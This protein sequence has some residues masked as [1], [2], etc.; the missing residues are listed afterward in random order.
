MDRSSERRRHTEAWLGSDPHVYDVTRI[1]AI[2]AREFERKDVLEELSTYANLYQKRE[3]SHEAHAVT[4]VRTWRF[5]MWSNISTLGCGL[6]HAKAIA[7]AYAMGLQEV[8]II[9]DDVQMI[10]VTD[11]AD[12]SELI[13]H[14]LRRLKESL[15]A[16]WQLLQL[17]STIYSPAKAAE[18]HNELM[19]RVIWHR[20]NGCAGD[21]YLILGAGAY[22]MSR[23]G[24][25]SY[26]Q[27]HLPESLSATIEEANSFH[28]LM[29]FRSTAISLIA[30]IAVYDL[31][32]VYTS[33]LP[34]FVPA[35]TVAQHS[36]IQAS[37]KGSTMPYAQHQLLQ[38]SVPALRDAGM[39]AIDSSNELLT[40]ALQNT[41]S[42]HVN[43]QAQLVQCMYNTR[44]VLVCE[45]GLHGREAHV[46]GTAMDPPIYDVSRA[47]LRL[48]MY[49][50]AESENRW[51]A[52]FWRTF[53]DSYLQRC[54]NMRACRSNDD[55]GVEMVHVL[56]PLFQQL[57]AIALP[58]HADN[59]A[60]AAAANRAC[61]HVHEEA[62]KDCSTAVQHVLESAI[63][64]YS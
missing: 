14:Y 13:W 50:L 52:E 9:E 47:D 1:S 5:G 8:L 39:F 40:A 26:L 45:L 10:N 30:D 3:F 36:T 32:N 16:N 46:N 60:I 31:E 55:G 28:G 42:V 20:K 64:K 11:T 44:Y 25:Q 37:D 57:R 6:S 21:S 18:I 49:L 38:I 22:M 54:H 15:P 19:Q 41:Q 56:V 23:S 43:S 29:D 2:D 33:N 34:L 62:L 35:T 53:L 61:A 24:M 27:K 51:K 17:F 7:V 48:Q 63:S 59:Q 4:Q 12:N 58:V